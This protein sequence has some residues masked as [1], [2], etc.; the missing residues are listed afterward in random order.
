M[1]EQPKPPD[2]RV[3]D[4]FSRGD[5]EARSRRDLERRRAR[6]NDDFWRALAMIGSVGWPIVLLTLG[7]ALL[8]RVCD[9]HWHTGVRFTLMLLALGASLGTWA[10]FRTVRGG[11]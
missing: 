1:P 8:G 2:P 10:A 7:G 9:T 6:G 5:I 4:R 3:P 11:A